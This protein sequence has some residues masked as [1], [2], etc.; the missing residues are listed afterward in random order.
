MKLRV[1]AWSDAQFA[2]SKPAWD[3]LLALSEADPLFMSWDWQWRWWTHHAGMLGAKLRVLAV[4]AGDELVALAPFYLHTVVVRRFSRVRRIEL[5]GIA[6]RD[7]R[8]F[9][10]DYLDVIAARGWEPSVLEAL[11]GWLEA[12]PE[13]DELV[14][15]GIRSS[16]LACRF[17]GQ[18]LRRLAYVREVDPMRAWCAPLPARF[19]DY[20]AGLEAEVRRKLFNQRRKLKEPDIQYAQPGDIGEYLGQ[21]ASYSAKRWGGGAPAED[22]QTAF[23]LGLGEAL[24]ARG[25]LRLSR[26]V[27]AEGPRS[28]LYA[29]RRNDTVYYVQS[30]FEPVGSRGVS[31]GYLHFGYAI[32]AACAEGAAQF[33]FLA[34]EG[35]HRDYK[36]DLRT[37]IVTIVSYHAV[38][39]RLAGWL[40]SLYARIERAR[41]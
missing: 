22:P 16:G 13:W 24:A 20:V 5:I 6:W 27:T 31:L 8:A 19:E 15:C 38:R 7:A 32:E 12:E 39:G 30:A 40:Y 2:A 4:Y 9:F 10:S 36:Q 28:I 37:E 11:A 25:E 17:A 35:R 18:E 14:L 41:V 23:L 1:D 33:D 34:G 26:L 29:V 21:L 3:D